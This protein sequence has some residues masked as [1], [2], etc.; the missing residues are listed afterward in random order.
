VTE[1]DADDLMPTDVREVAIVAM[2]SVADDDR[3]GGDWVPPPPPLLPLVLKLP[4]NESIFPDIKLP[5]LFISP[6]LSAIPLKKSFLV[7]A[8]EEVVVVVE[9]EEE[10]TGE[11]APEAAPLFTE[12]FEDLLDSSDRRKAEGSVR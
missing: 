3:G 9:D 8:D 2:L 10:E 1:A 7:G 12:P 5:K 11:V 4:R 6:D